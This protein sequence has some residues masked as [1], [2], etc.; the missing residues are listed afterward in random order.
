MNASVIETM[1]VDHCALLPFH[2]HC[3]CRDT[4]RDNLPGNEEGSLSDQVIR[5]DESIHARDSS[6]LKG[7][8][9]RDGNMVSPVIYWTLWTDHFDT[10]A[11]KNRNRDNDTLTTQGG[12]REW[13]LDF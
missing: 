5:G 4:I 10:E 3:H 9:S 6:G 8:N 2:V 1:D 11:R 12:F 7:G 13:C